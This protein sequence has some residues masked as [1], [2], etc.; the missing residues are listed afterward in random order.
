MPAVTNARSQPM[1][2]GTFLP[3]DRELD[4][5]DLAV[6]GTLPAGLRGSFLRNGP[7]AMFEPKGRYHMFD[8]DGM[9]HRVMLDEGRATYRNRWI[10]TKGLEAEV[11]AGHSLYGG[12]GDLDFPSR[13]D[14]GDAGPIK[15][16]A[17]TN[18]VRHAGRHL[19]LYEAGPAVEVTADLDTIGDCDFGGGLPGAVTA[20]PRIDPRT[21]EMHAFTYLPWAPFL[22]YHHI[23]AQG[24]HTHSIDLQVPE[25]VVMHDFVI[26]PEHAVFL[27]SPLVFDLDAAMNGGSMFRWDPD[28]GTRIGIMPLDATSADDVR[29]IET[30]D[31]YV[32]HFWNGWVE[33]DTLT[34]S[35]STVRAGAYTSGADGAMEREGADA[36]PGRPVRYTVDLAAGTA[37]QEQI[38]DLGGDFTRIND[39]YTGMRSRHHYMGAF[40]GP[41]DIIGHFDTVVAYD[42]MAGTRTSWCAGPGCI[43]GDASFA[44]D[45]DGT[46]ENDGWLLTVM[47]DRAEG[48]SD[49]AVID[50]RDIA[51]GPVARVHLPQRLPFGFHSN[52]FPAEG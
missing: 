5:A 3:V 19:A 13:K 46:A 9:L 32:N 48:R 50:A 14:V 22:S 12:M 36:E 4:V 8:G 28:H 24:T 41:A 6:T 33:G 40:S 52:W 35:G 49:L 31:A 42:D 37:K 20:H 34:F 17:N 16:P 45:P 38:D 39:A 21:G 51:A 25:P 29:W 15:N 7:N 18:I 30:E 1:L 47:T 23:D 2:N 10:R 11:R 27:E 26:T 43:V 44:A